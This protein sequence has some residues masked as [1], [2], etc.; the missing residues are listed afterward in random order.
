MAM[1]EHPAPAAKARHLYMSQLDRLAGF[2]SGGARPPP[3]CCGASSL[4]ESNAHRICLLGAT[5]PP[6]RENQNCQI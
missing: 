1:R 4:S 6:H 5:A 2:V 3:R